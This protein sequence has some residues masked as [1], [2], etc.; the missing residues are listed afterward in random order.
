MKK[1]HKNIKGLTLVEL[2]IAIAIFG[3]VSVAFLMIFSTSMLITVRAGNKEIALMQ[4][5]SVLDD[6]KTNTT[7][8]DG[9]PRY[10]NFDIDDFKDTDSIT[11]EIVYFS[12]SGASTS[13]ITRPGIIYE[14]KIDGGA[15]G[16]HS[17]AKGFK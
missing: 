1:I 9:D 2:I 10:A 3:M 5:A 15:E 14:V 6:Y 12:P 13:P 7:F 16:K 17:T 11:I 8:S 4:A